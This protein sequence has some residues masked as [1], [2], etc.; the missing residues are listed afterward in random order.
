MKIETCLLTSK[1]EI[2]FFQWNNS[3][4]CLIKSV[5]ACWYFLLT[6]CNMGDTK[7]WG[8]ILQRKFDGDSSDAVTDECQNALIC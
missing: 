3:M 1:L 6:V 4:D 7:L 5:F 8:W 2:I